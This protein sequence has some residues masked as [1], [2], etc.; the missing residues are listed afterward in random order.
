MIGTVARKLQNGNLFICPDGT[1]FS[2]RS[3]HLFCHHQAL[4]RADIDDDSIM[5]GAKIEFSVK[6]PRWK[7]GKQEC[8]NIQLLAA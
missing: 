2:D 8:D 3:G 5:V 4:R 7:D 1:S 6:P